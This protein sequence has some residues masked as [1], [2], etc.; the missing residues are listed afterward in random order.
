[1]MSEQKH[2]ASLLVAQDK[3]TNKEIAE[4]VGIAPRTLD[5]WKCEPEFKE[6]VQAH[7]NA[8]MERIQNKGIADKRRRV[9]QLNERWRKA[10]AIVEAC[11]KDPELRKLPGGKTGFV[12]KRVRAIPVGQG[13]Y[14]EIE[15]FFF[16]AKLFMSLLRIEEQ[17][18]R[19]LGQWDEKKPDRKILRLSDLTPDEVQS[20]MADMEKRFGG[21][22]PTSGP[23]APPTV[24]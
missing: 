2:L 13:E 16:D 9:F 5:N 22:L 19:E 10:Q 24:Q 15:E 3:L 20:L 4:K 6:A 1:M 17:A 11:A 7:L 8:W 21:I 18:A 14:S 23:E 12:R